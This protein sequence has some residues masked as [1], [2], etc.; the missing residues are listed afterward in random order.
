MA[1]NPITNYAT[2]KAAVADYLGETIPDGDLSAIV[3]FAEARL[4]RKLKAVQGEVSL[5]GTAGVATIDVSSYNVIEPK[6]LF[7]TTY[8]ED[9]EIPMRAPGTFEYGD[10][11]EYPTA[12][13]LISNNDTLRF[14]APLDANH[15]FRFR[16]EGRFALSDSAPTN[17]LLTNHPDVYFAA[18]M[19]WGNI[20]HQNIN[21][22][23]SFKAILDEF[24]A[25][26]QHYISQSDRAL[27]RVDPGLSM[28]GGYG[29]YDINS[30]R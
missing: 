29:V 20:R 12:W 1:I 22:A 2:L 14:A 10:S 21:G 24:M 18:C 7:L 26:T 9:E 6:A 27:L 11:N 23:S 25:E 30:D 19:L 3:A 15:T 17:E 16:Y 8:E 28:I 5:S 4:N 13:T